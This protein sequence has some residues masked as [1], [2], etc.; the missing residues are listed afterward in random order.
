MA[1]KTAVPV[2]TDAAS[3]GSRRTRSGHVSH[4]ASVI[5][6][7]RMENRVDPLLGQFETYLEASG[8]SLRTVRTY[9]VAVRQL[10]AFIGER[11][12]DWHEVTPLDC[13][14]WIAEVVRKGASASWRNQCVSAGKGL[15][16]SWR[17]TCGT[18]STARLWPS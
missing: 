8:K 14:A 13:Q 4:K 11:G 17:N 3:R 15:F 9:M 18:A 1:A 6:L 5:S 2:Y 7:A 16:G 12:L 10:E